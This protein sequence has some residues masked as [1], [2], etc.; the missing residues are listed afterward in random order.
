MQGQDERASPK[1]EPVKKMRKWKKE[2]TK[3]KKA[4]KTAKKV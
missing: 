2:T 3:K 4:A 1:E